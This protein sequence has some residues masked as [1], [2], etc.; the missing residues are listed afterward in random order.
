MH[1]ERRASGFYVGG[2]K[3]KEA[4]HSRR[5]DGRPATSG[6]PRSAD[7]RRVRRHVSNVPEAE[8]K[9][10]RQLRGE[11]ISITAKPPCSSSLALTPARL[12]ADAAGERNSCRQ[13]LCCPREQA[14]RCGVSQIH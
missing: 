4:G 5:F 3:A 6:P 2:M 11:L 1:P 9:L 10:E 7:I 12:R 13:N 8:V 14:D